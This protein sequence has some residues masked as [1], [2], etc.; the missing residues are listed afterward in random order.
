MIYYISLKEYTNIKL[1]YK[2][3]VNNVYFYYIKL[4]IFYNI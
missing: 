4:N 2:K 1:S 3:L